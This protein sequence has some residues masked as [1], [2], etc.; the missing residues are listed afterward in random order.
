MPAAHVGADHVV[1]LDPGEEIPEA[2]SA[3]AARHG[4]RA[5]LVVLGIGQLVEARIGYWNGQEYRPLRLEAP[6]ELLALH[7]TIAEVDGQP[8]LHLHVAVADAQYHV[9]GGHL[10]SARVGVIA[11]VHLRDLPGH[12]FARPMDEAV[13]LRRL[14]PDGPGQ[15]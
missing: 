2:L 4:L 10:L 14:E 9:L 11:E 1:R 5:G 12:A 6:V 8:S 15:S 13:G 3:Y 7:G